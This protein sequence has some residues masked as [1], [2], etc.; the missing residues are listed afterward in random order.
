MT[1]LKRSFNTQ[2][3]FTH[4][5]CSTCLIC[6]LIHKSVMN[7]T[8]TIMSAIGSATPDTNMDRTI[9]HEILE[10]KLDPKEKEFKRVYLDVTATN[11]AGFETTGAVLRLVCFHVFSNKDILQHLRTEIANARAEE[12]DVMTLKVLEK[13][14]YLTATLSRFPPTFSHPSDISEVSSSF[15]HNHS[16]LSLTLRALSS[17]RLAP[18]SRNSDANDTHCP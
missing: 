12:G 8:K 9:V 4:V 18:Q 3:Y 15:Y 13:L 7:D 11:G 14:P 5:P 17:G 1:V 10:S 2:R 6:S 16:S